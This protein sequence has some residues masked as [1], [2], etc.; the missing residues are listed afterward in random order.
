MFSLPQA[1]KVEW[2]PQKIKQNIYL[3]LHFMRISQVLKIAFLG[4]ALSCA[5]LVA[6][7]AQTT[8]TWIGAS[9]GEWNT[10]ANWD[11]GAPPLD[12]TTNA[13][14][15]SGLTVNYNLPMEA[16]SFGI[17]T[18]FGILNINTNGFNCSAIYANLPG[19]VIDAVNITN[20]G[21]VVTV[22][23]PFS[24]GTNG[25][26]T[27]GAG[28]SLTA[29][30][31]AV[32]SGLT[33]KSAGTS[34]FTN[35]GGVFNSSSTSVGSSTST[36]TGRFTIIGGTNYL[37]NTSVGRYASASAS[38]LG[39][40][41]GLVVFGGTVN[42]SNLTMSA[43]SYGTAYIAGG[44][45]TN[46]GNVAINGVTGGRYL[47][48]VQAG[49]L[50][51][52]PDPGIIYENATTAGTETARYQVTGGTNIIGG[53]YLGASN[54]AVTATVTVTI[55]G[56]VYIGSQGIN[57]NGVV[58]NTITLSGGGL[59][60]ATT[61]WNGNA[62]MSLGSG[63]FTFQ[64]A[65]QNNTPYNIALA[66]VLSGSGILNKSGGGTLALTATNTYSGS[67]LINAGSLALTTNISGA[68]GSIANSSGIT[69]STNATFDVSGLGAGG[70]TLGSAKTIAGVG[71]VV[72]NFTAGSGANINPAG[73]G[74]QGTLTFSNGLTA[75]G[76]NF[77]MELGSDPTGNTTVND[78]VNIVGDL[79]LSGVNSVIVTPVGS[80][81]LG[82][83]RL[84]KYS[85]NLSGNL[86]NLT[87][88][89][90]TLSNPPGEI[91]LIVTSV[92]PAANLFWKGD[93][94]ANLWDT[95]T[96]SNWLNGV[97]LDRFYTGDTNTFNDNTTNFVVNISGTVTPAST[98]VVTVNA[99]N[100]Y[101]FAGAGD[102][103]GTTGLTKTNSG[104]LTILTTNDYTGVT[105][106][107]GGILSVSNLAYGGASSP[108]G[109]AG[110]TPANL[111]F[112]GGT[113]AYLGAN[114]TTDRG[115]TFQTNGGS[116][117]VIDGT[118]LTLAGYL[119]GPGALTKTGN[120]QLDL[121]GVNDYSGGT[122]ISAGTLDINPA[123]TIGTNTLTLAGVTSPA[124]NRF[125]GDAEVLANTLNVVGTN[126]YILNGGNDTISSVTGT[127]TVSLESASGQVLTLQSTDMSGFTGTF[128]ADTLS[129]LRFFVGGGLTIDASG[130]TFNLGT[131]T[132]LLNNR[133]GELTILLGALTGGPLTILQGASSENNPTTYVIGGNNL[134]TTFNGAISEVV[135]S[136]QVNIVKTGTG[137]F[138][139]NSSGITTNITQ[140]G[141]FI[142]TNISYL[143]RLT[144]TGSTTISNGVL[145]LVAPTVLTNT[146]SVTLA[147][148]T[149]VLD[150]S[151]MGVV[152][153][154][155]DS[156]GV[157]VT[158]QVLVTNGV[159]EVISGQALN[160]FGTILGSLLADAGSSVNVGLPGSAGVLN[161]TNIISLNGATTMKISR[162]GSPVSDEL[163][164]QQ[165]A[166]SFGG[167]LTVTNI[168]GQ[169]QAGDTFTLFSAAGSAYNNSFSSIILPANA[170]W[171]TSKLA[172]N[173]TI[174]VTSSTGPPVLGGANFSQLSSGSITLSAS[175]NPGAA[176]SVLSSTNVALPLV[177]WTTAASGNF[178]SN[179]NYNPTI[180][181][182]PAAP[183]QYFI[184][185]AQ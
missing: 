51:V 41:E 84:I 93:G 135:S 124:T 162:V 104:N 95:A 69:V 116:L 10:G 2:L 68:M 145:A 131:S 91:D 179:G 53:I 39:T 12:S 108:I 141:L 44:V 62:N 57:T 155:Y 89:A 165:S 13:F 121:T 133:N 163:V 73:I 123:S 178:D 184:L 118:T 45:V 115:A 119:T 92:R 98:T 48:V 31:F 56:T 46:Y 120:G 5:G 81:G 171:D 136:R 146:P 140:D 76:A 63:T 125:A 164:A 59:I 156:D 114:Q 60:G 185:Q 183:Q 169:L 34:T 161:V 97:S 74:A 127:G 94:S 30:S 128:Y 148:A 11:A 168:G 24:L 99:V 176:V 55:G 19:S 105:T 52:V 43:A 143:S 167:T 166:I 126:N 82:T 180:S 80:L 106:F 157:T 17:L 26:A 75:A 54:S 159:F 71:S 151:S 61:G 37:G 130:A 85:G 117:N 83:Y 173:G 100:N 32:S 14:I 160:G 9:G 21:S 8:A 177:Q 103:T 18:N 25:Q 142:T 70:F 122:I 38:T 27:L 87:C 102:I 36:G 181:V 58:T 138:T 149:A 110:N 182:N 129:N 88:L 79:D 132:N 158:N 40:T 67:T 175:G 22:S 20:I 6:A 150:A 86:A 28:A 50:F 107:G 78:M 109:A 1:D 3:N 144:Y 152:S 33:T 139:L 101:T 134:S 15:G 174:R 29:G 111:V 42:M 66:G 64:A 172:V 7:S 96:S 112:N 113:L 147:S 153:N 154:Q 49:G 77:N 137:T 47:R 35:R 170:T 65:D 72:G 4:T 90:G 16:T 23:G